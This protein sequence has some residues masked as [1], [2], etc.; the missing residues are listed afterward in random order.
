[1]D[2]N[3][4][5]SHFCCCAQFYTFY[6]ILLLVFVLSI[7][8]IV[9]LLGTYKLRVQSTPGIAPPFVR[10][11]LQLYIEAARKSQYWNSF[12]VIKVT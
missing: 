11:T 7:S 4:L 2:F 12:K 1:M 8:V 10:R 5:G 3:T 6:T 9:L